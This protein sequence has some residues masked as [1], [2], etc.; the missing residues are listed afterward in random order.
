MAFGTKKILHSESR[1]GG[2]ILKVLRVHTE[3]FWVKTPCCTLEVNAFR[4]TICLHP[5]GWQKG[6]LSFRNITNRLPEAKNYI[7]KQK[8]HSVIVAAVGILE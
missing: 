2:D 7:I 4:G 1:P 8:N 6:S 3:I 5:Q